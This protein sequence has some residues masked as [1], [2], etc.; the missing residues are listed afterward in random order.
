[1]KSTVHI[2]KGNILVCITQQ[3]TGCGIIYLKQ[4]SIVECAFTP[5]DYHQT[6]HVYRNKE[7]KGNDYLHPISRKKL[8]AATEEEVAMYHNG[9]Y[10]IKPVIAK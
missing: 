7:S 1:M 4:D 8:R 3:S 10:F 6:I 5:K 9:I 2:E